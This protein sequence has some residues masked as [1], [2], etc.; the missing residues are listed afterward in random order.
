M[1][2]RKPNAVIGRPLIALALAAVA[3]I[4]SADGPVA[5]HRYTI[6]LD[7]ALSRLW[8]EARFAVTLDSVQAQSRDAGKFLIV[9]DVPCTKCEYCGEAYFKAEVLKRIEKEFNAIYYQGKETKQKLSVPV[10]RFEQIGELT[11]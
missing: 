11:A 9:D 10:E 3:S 5:P 2:S 8:V 7:N 6:S 4:A 1:T